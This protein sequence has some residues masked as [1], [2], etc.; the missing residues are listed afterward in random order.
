M[1]ECIVVKFFIMC[2]VVCG[3]WIKEVV[4]IDIVYERGL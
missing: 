3:F 4:G 1:G 2:Y